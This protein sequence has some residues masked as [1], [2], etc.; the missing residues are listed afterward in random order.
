MPGG[1]AAQFMKSPFDET[2]CVVVL[3]DCFGMLALSLIQRDDAETHEPVDEIAD[4]L[5]CFTSWYPVGVF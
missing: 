3:K 5:Q 1:V 2:H 4:L